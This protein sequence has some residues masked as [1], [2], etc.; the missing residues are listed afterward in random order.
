MCHKYLEYMWHVALRLYLQTYSDLQD[1]DCLL[2]VFFS[3]NMQYAHLHFRA[4]EQGRN[5]GAV[6]VPA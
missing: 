6:A 2:T 1:R 5:D 3:S 4:K